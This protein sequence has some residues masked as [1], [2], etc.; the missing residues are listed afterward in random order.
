MMPPTSIDG[1]DITGATIDGT[2]V[3][4]ITVDGQTVFSAGPSLTDIVAP[5]NLVAWYPFE[6]GAKD[7]TRTGG[8]LDNAGVSV[9]SSIDHSGTLSGSISVQSSGGNNDL[10]AGTNSGSLDCNGGSMTVTNHPDINF[11]SGNLTITWWVNFNTNT[12]GDIF[13]KGGQGGY[14]G[15][16]QDSDTSTRVGEQFNSGTARISATLNQLDFYAFKDDGSNITLFKNGSSISDSAPNVTYNNS[17]DLTIGNGVDGP[18]DGL[19]D[20]FRI[21]DTDLTNIQIQSIYDNTET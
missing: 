1:T 14:F 17:G 7:E 3:Q 16:L 5:G 2:D 6:D 12:Q 11:S 20:D 9:G 18:I 4:E 19:I 10:D 8:A 15:Y 13:E 21:Y